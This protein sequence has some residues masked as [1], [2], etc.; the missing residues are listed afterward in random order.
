MNENDCT[1]E[2]VLKVSVEIVEAYSARN[3]L[4]VFD[5]EILVDRIFN[6]LS[7]NRSHSW[8]EAMILLERPIVRNHLERRNLEAPSDGSD[9]QGRPPINH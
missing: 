4:S 6:I 2:D 5:S 8:G 3:K 7:E 1:I 9:L